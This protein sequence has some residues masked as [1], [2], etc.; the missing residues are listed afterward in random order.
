[1]RCS[2]LLAAAALA[3]G[4]SAGGLGTA[5]AQSDRTL[6]VNCTVAGHV[7]CGENGPLGGPAH[8]RGVRAYGAVG[9]RAVVRHMWRDGREITVRSRRCY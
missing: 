9:C 7:R 8:L 3:F 2:V 1:M 4:L 5:S 6:G